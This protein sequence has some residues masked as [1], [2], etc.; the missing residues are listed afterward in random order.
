M[1]WVQILFYSSEIFTLSHCRTLLVG[2][3]LNHT[4]ES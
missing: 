1:S 4:G 2:V 3:E